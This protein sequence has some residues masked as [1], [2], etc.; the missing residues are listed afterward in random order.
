M[1]M[2]YRELAS[3]YAHGFK[4]LAP[5]R[6]YI[7]VVKEKLG[8]PKRKAAVAIAILVFFLLPV[9][10]SVQAPAE[11]APRDPL[12]VRSPLEGIIFKFRVRP[13]E[14]V[15]KGQV[16]FE[17]DRTNLETRLQV[18]SKAYQVAAEVY[19][20][21]SQ[22]AIEDEKARSSIESSQGKMQ[23]REAELAFSRNL[24]DKIEVKAPRDGIAVFAD[25]NDWIG[26]SVSVGE[27][28]VVIA[29][30][31]N[32][33]MLIFLPVADAIALQQGTKVT[34][35][36]TSDPQ[37]PRDGRLTYASYKSEVTPA[38]L[39]AYRLKADFLADGSAP[40]R[41]G[42][43]GIAKIYGKRV[44]LAYYIFRRP[45]TALRQWLGW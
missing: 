31:A 34:L 24:F 33:E 10:L 27:R 25:A 29:D 5:P 41:V 13:N 23:G 45:L 7:R 2:C 30:P 32:V 36:L 12:V 14:E 4:A 28:I 17:F 11:V 37:R 26:K 1:F 6:K 44:I 19:R 38:G 8:T 39:V 9:R 3:I 43:T 35:Y 42:L 18:A 15:K 16:L 22:M 21:T 40:P 20:Q